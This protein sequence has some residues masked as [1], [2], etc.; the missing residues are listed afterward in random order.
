MG[1][2]ICSQQYHR[3]TAKLKFDLQITTIIEDCKTDRNV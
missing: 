3:I 2:S 1:L